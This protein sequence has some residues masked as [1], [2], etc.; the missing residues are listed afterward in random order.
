MNILGNNKFG[1]PI[2]TQA[3]NGKPSPAP[4][5]S[6]SSSAGALFS[7]VLEQ[8]A[9][10]KRESIDDRKGDERR[11]DKYPAQK[12][13]SPRR[14]KEQTLTAGEGNGGDAGA[15]AE[16]EATALPGTP[17]APGLQGPGISDR[18]M[19]APV[20]QPI[21]TM[22]DKTPAMPT[23]EAGVDNLT[24]RVVW[25]DFLRKMKDE[26]GVSA[27][28]VL[29]AFTQL[30][31]QD[32]AMPPAETLDKIVM[33]L[34]LEGPQA[35]VAK[36]HF[37]ELVSKTNSPTLGDEI[38]ASHKQINLTLMSQRELQR[39]AL[40]KSLKSMDEN[41]FL[42]SSAHAEAQA[43][44][45]QLMQQQMALK[46]Q[47]AG[48]R[49]DSPAFFNPPTTLAA[50][51]PE[52]A[53]LGARLMNPP[54]ADGALAPLTGEVP[55]MAAGM[56]QDKFAVNGSPEGAVSGKDMNAILSKMEQAT[57]DDQ[58][59][60]EALAKQLSAKP[61]AM[62][63]GGAA[64]AASGAA[65]STAAGTAAAPVATPA[66]MAAALNGI[67]SGKT[68]E[69]AEFS[70]EGD[71]SS[72]S[73]AGLTQTLGATAHKAGGPGTE[74]KTEMAQQVNGAPMN[75]EIPELMKNAEVLMK[76]GGGEMKVV[77]N[78]DGL[79]EVAM[80]VNVEHGKVS[81]QMITESDE[82]KRLI[83]RELNS[84]KLGLQ[85]N[86]LRVDTIKVDTATNMGQ[87]LDQQY[88]DAQRQF[89]QSTMEQFRQNQQ[90]WR[91]SFFD[92]PSARAYRG[93]AEAPRDV[94]SPARP[95]NVRGT[96]RRVD[97]V[98]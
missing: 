2:A 94:K 42:N 3:A 15:E 40:Q 78:P 45:R 8:K 27:E 92:V 21:S 69:D 75:P 58:K 10:P 85:Q 56:P 67:F 64:A 84:L 30:S 19:G 74:F 54:A 91:K 39:K 87:Q 4:K 83:E 57:P 22:A 41:F 48:Q 14:P 43:Q 1:L 7:D 63:A 20:G 26:L 93:Q 28:D 82:A 89:A 12:S 24:R 51:T 59:S 86:N 17:S 47:A 52:A 44:L 36:T 73:S 31:D 76:E 72:D 35:Q 6:D 61:S 50:G 25:N 16:V 71:N 23:E 29:N 90:G 70:D 55:A 66:G 38:S 5:K 60:L 96:G 88:Q 34:G 33:A 11:A 37:Q 81:V 53:E 9:Q 49:K 80:K 46:D 79:G 77:M 18:M 62:P 95:S 68:S 98:A 65:P 97:L 32:L 13:L